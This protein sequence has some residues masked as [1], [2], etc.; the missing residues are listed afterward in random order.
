MHRHRL[1]SQPWLRTTALWGV[2]SNIYSIQRGTIVIT[3]ASTSNTATITAV[4][5][6]NSIITFL[7]WNLAGA[8]NP[9]HAFVRLALTNATTVTATKGAGTGGADNVTVGFEVVAYAPGVIKS[10]Q[11]GTIVCAAGTATATIT[12]VNTAK[13]TLH[14]I[15]VSSV[16]T[17]AFNT[18]MPSIDL[19]NS[20]TITATSTAADATVGYQAVEWN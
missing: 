1:L 7:G 16:N 14:C 15:G 11:R 2:S 17:G 12:S 13:T 3:G 4:D 18:W 20:T 5:V 19:T 8:E 10:V 9:D 6:N